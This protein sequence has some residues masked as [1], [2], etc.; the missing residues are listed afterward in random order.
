METLIN[1]NNKPLVVL[2]FLISILLLIGGLKIAKRLLLKISKSSILMT[3]VMKFYPSFELVTWYGY[4][5][6][7]LPYFYRHNIYFAALL[8]LFLITIAIWIVLFSIKDIIAGYILR[9]NPAIAKQKK[10]IVDNYTLTITSLMPG[11]LE[12]L[13]DDNSIITIRYSKLIQATIKQ[14]TDSEN[15]QSKTIQISLQKTLYNDDT[16]R[17]I[18]SFLLSQPNYAVKQSPIIRKIGE[19]AT[20][21]KLSVTFFVLDSEKVFEI[22]NEVRMQY[23]K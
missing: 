21:V 1:Y 11:Y 20:K 17:S 22:E 15:I 2:I 10:I 13:L 8:S 19:D 23:E 16:A 6:L 4:M 12:G 14:I 7:I 9:N 18:K 3:K 5:F